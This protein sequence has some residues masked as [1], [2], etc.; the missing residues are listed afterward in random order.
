MKNK[1]LSL[2][3]A[4]LCVLM[5]IPFTAL[6]ASAV[7]YTVRPLTRDQFKDFE[8]TWSAEGNFDIQGMNVQKTEFDGVPVNAYS[9]SADVEKIT[10]YRSKDGAYN[11]NYQL[12]LRNFNNIMTDANG[13]KVRIYDA[14]Y[15]EIEYY[16]DTTGRDE[17]DTNG[18]DLTANKMRFDL[19]RHI[20][21]D[22]TGDRAQGPWIDAFIT[23]ENNIVANEW[24]TQVFNL[25]DATL[26]KYPGNAE[27]AGWYEVPEDDHY[28]GQWKFYPFGANGGLQL[29]HGDV[30]YIK[31][32]TF[33]SF[34]P[35]EIP[36]SERTISYYASEDA[37]LMG[38]DP[39]I[40]DTAVDL[41]VITLPEMPADYIPADAIFNGWF[42]S[43]SQKIYKAGSSFDVNTGMDVEFFGAFSYPDEVTFW[44]GD[45]SI[46]ETWFTDQTYKMP[47]LPAD[48]VIPEGK[49]FTGWLDTEGNNFAAGS[50]YTYTGATTSFEANFS[51]PTVV[52]YSASGA[53]D[54]VTDTVYTSI[55]DAISSIA[56][57]G[58]VGTVII[59]GEFVVP[60]GSD[61][62]L[63]LSSCSHIEMKGYTPD[64][65]ITFCAMNHGWIDG[66]GTELVIDDIIV[67]R[68]D[69]NADEQF[70]ILDGVNMTFGAGCTFAKGALNGS[71]PKLNIYIAQLSGGKKGYGV[72]VN[73]P[74]VA[75]KQFAPVGNWSNGGYANTG[76]YSITV[77]DGKIDS[78][79]AVT[80]NGKSDYANKSK[81]TGNVDITVNGGTVTTLGTANHNAGGDLTGNAF[82]TVN[83]GNISQIF[84]GDERANDNKLTSA[85]GGMA[86]VINSKSIVD[87]GF[88]LPTIKNGQP[89]D[90]TKGV[91]VLNN[92]ELYDTVPEITNAQYSVYVE[93]GTAIPDISGDTVRFKITSDDAALTNVTANGMIITPEGGYYTLGKG[94]TEIVF[95]SP[96]AEL[97]SVTYKNG[98]ATVHGGMFGPG[99]SV[100]L[101]KNAFTEQGRYI[102][103][104]TY[105]GT[106]Y[107]V[108]DVFTMPAENVVLEAVWEDM[109][110]NAR[111][112]SS[113][114]SSSNSGYTSGSP[115]AS[116]DAAISALNGEDGY[117]VI[118][119]EVKQFFTPSLVGADQSVT[120]TGKDPVTGE[121]YDAFI[122]R[123]EKSARP[124]LY[125]GH[126]TLEYLGD[127]NQ[128]DG[129]NNIPYLIGN[130][131]FTI[132]EGYK[133][134]VNKSGT[135][136]ESGVQI[137]VTANGANPVIDINSKISQIQLMDWGDSTISGDLNIN[138]GPNAN[139]TEYFSLGGDCDAAKTAKVNG[140]TYV[141][142]D[143]SQ[144]GK[145]IYLGGVKTNSVTVLNGL[146]VILS[147]T[148]M[149][150]A[151][152]E[153]GTY[154]NNGATYI[155][156][157]NISVEGGAVAKSDEFGKVNVTIPEGYK[158]IVEAEDGS[159]QTYTVSG[160]VALPEGNSTISIV[161]EAAITVNY[162]DGISETYNGGETLTFPEREAVDGQILYYW[163]MNGQRYFPGDTFVFPLTSAEYEVTGTR[164][165]ED[166]VVYIDMIN[167]NDSNDGLSAAAAFK[168]VATV[169][170]ALASFKNTATMEIIGEYTY[171]NHNMMLPAYSG[172]LTVQ[173]GT[174]SS[175]GVIIIRCDSVFKDTTF[176]LKNNWKQ[177]ELN[178]KNVV[179]ESTVKKAE[180]S[181]P[182]NIHA[183]KAG[184][185]MTGDQSVEILGGDFAAVMAG[186]YYVS[187]GG[188]CTWNGNF[189]LKVGGTANLGEVKIGDGYTGHD[190]KVVINGAV[191]VTVESG[192]TLGSANAIGYAKS[193]DSFRIY[194][195]G[196]PAKLNNVSADYNAKLYN[197]IGI[198]PVSIDGETMTFDAPANIVGGANTNESFVLACP[199]AHGAYNITA[200]L[201]VSDGLTIDG[202][203]IRIADADIKQGLRFVATY[204][205]ETA[206][207]YAG[208]EYGFVV[209][210]TAVLAGAPLDATK[211]YTYNEKV[212]EPALV[213]AKLL[214]EDGEGFVKYT[215]CLTDILVDNY[216]TSYTAITYIK[217][218]DS[219]IYG[220][221]YSASVYAIAEAAV[222]A[223]ND[224]TRPLEADVLAVM[225]QIISDA[226]AK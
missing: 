123:A 151:N 212:F 12:N 17:T 187:A 22:Y 45:N 204:T 61:K 93:G 95:T 32:I 186:P 146:Q 205:D 73:S 192:A 171:D 219:Y 66:V 134:Y 39:I 200:G 191:N 55:T 214:Y 156:K 38:D 129:A 126:V 100:T 53:I 89:V 20:T 7:E 184:S 137:D 41:D 59:D 102:S 224:G 30:M 5:A 62:R 47:A 163:T 180:D 43:V 122:Y 87:N 110:V 128:F 181:M 37:Y 131:H 125:R 164:V 194:N 63:N 42:E 99:S 52:Y 19:Y 29:Y 18:M 220:E 28:L 145:P 182:L 77:N 139:F 31:S 71:E 149:T 50:S 216:K 9:K 190:G 169:E 157:A 167:G 133:F 166:S 70:I 75:I 57:N 127:Y 141:T 138:V 206:A 155:V 198:A 106:T 107:S 56:D 135:R 132:G 215:A 208:K 223:H 153:K 221:T 162:D 81:I 199:E 86:L 142:V 82:V 222:A 14:A 121:I 40:T 178:G 197:F 147:N 173:G 143:G 217:D 160:K 116:I 1:I 158:A 161:S 136:T 10:A 226:D 88:T 119:D 54:G 3:L 175:T 152:H 115:L 168:T 108:N 15:V 193:Y 97:Y 114:G 170:K 112:V 74:E 4:V 25:K 179:F 210:P 124:G 21:P 189:N 34:D 23:A 195:Y 83:G 118:M 176:N 80:R 225:Q 104:W 67:A 33:T 26:T 140:K 101:S 68:G 2:V 94:K 202:A 27:Y 78:L 105:G 24:A 69:T 103:G 79:Y 76:D 209:I 46:T 49:V 148:N 11:E 174:I 144:C 16:Y 91:F 172:V 65:K 218:G 213:P 185:N 113:T 92:T 6:Q 117:V 64:A 13:K 201:N 58:G 159:K 60:V 203:Q 150:V 111:Y 109:T 188:T 85:M 154:T 183:G 196:K 98:D 36:S 207:K 130:M 8:A 120:L 35:A 211:T 96:D 90:T 72:T 84:F 44:Y 165:A 177:I 51:D 48:A